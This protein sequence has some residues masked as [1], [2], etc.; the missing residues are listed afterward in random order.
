MSVFNSTSGKP[1]K[2]LRILPRSLRYYHQY[3]DILSW[4]V[5]LP[6]KV[7]VSHTKCVGDKTKTVFTTQKFRKSAAH[8]FIPLKIF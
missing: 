7:C 2:F 1:S 5:E 6:D 8:W 3:T 4:I